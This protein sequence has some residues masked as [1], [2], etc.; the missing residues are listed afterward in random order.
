M[1][2]L[3]GFSSELIGVLLSLLVLL[4]QAIGAPLGV[5]DLRVELG[6]LGRASRALALLLG[7]THVTVL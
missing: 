2:Q 5:S 7:F 6:L 3:L 4:A 1:L